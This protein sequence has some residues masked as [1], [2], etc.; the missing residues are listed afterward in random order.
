MPTPFVPHTPEKQKNME[1]TVREA[2]LLLKLRKYPYG[3]FVVHKAEN[4]IVRVEITHS[5]KIEEDK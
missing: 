2:I 5:L 3:K 1:V 4:L